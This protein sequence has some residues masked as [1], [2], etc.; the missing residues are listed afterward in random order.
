MTDMEED[1]ATR[2]SAPPQMFVIPP[3]A[4][5]PEMCCV[6][7]PT[8]ELMVQHLLQTAQRMEELERA[9]DMLQTT[10]DRERDEHAKEIDY[11]RG[12]LVHSDVEK[13]LMEFKQSTANVIEELCISLNK[14]EMD[15]VK[16]LDDP[17]LKELDRKLSKLGREIKK[18]EGANRVI[19]E[20]ETENEFLHNE[21]DGVN[22]TLKSFKNLDADNKKVKA[23]LLEMQRQAEIDAKKCEKAE[24]VLRMENMQMAQSMMSML[25]D[26]TKLRELFTALGDE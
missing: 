9:N 11:L 3:R 13:G 22:A 4:V 6:Y 15:V 2:F 24:M 25:A 20:L 16:A 23:S 26:N 8:P 1:C 18:A 14:L 19:M 17:R 21:I 5:T 7:L 12:S 10:L